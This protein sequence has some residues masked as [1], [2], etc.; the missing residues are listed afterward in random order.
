MHIEG[1]RVGEDVLVT[2]SGLIG[3]DDAF[4]GFD[5]L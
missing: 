1:V 4:T 2:V 3:G 5:E